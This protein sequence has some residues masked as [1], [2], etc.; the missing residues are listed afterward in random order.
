MCCA[1]RAEGVVHTQLGEPQGGSEG[2][3]LVDTDIEKKMRGKK[4]FVEQREG[5]EGNRRSAA[6]SRKLR[7]MEQK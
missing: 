4:V 2:R 5:K 7:G 6:S 1:H 3:N